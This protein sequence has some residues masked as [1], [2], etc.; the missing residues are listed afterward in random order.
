MFAWIAKRT[1][2]QLPSPPVFARYEVAREACR[3]VAPRSRTLW[4]SNANVAS[5]A[6]AS[7][8]EFM[9]FT[10]V[11]ILQSEVNPERFYTG[12]TKDLRERM[13][14]HNAGGIPRTSKWRPWTLKTYIVM[15]DRQRAAELEKYLKSHSGRTF[16]KKHL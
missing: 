16:V 13:K 11:Y 12:L 10:Y 4:F 1:G 9:P 8:F 6:P 3:G 5:Y 7:Q 14:R 15:S 2:V